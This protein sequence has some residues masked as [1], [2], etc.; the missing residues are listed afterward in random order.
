M[1][2]VGLLVL[3]GVVLTGG[4]MVAAAR[5]VPGAMQP[6]GAR[7]ELTR[8]MVQAVEEVDAMLGTAEEVEPTQL[9][10]EDEVEAAPAVIDDPLPVKALPAATVCVGATPVE[11]HGHTD[12]DCRVH[13]VMVR[14]E[15]S[16]RPESKWVRR[17]A[18]KKS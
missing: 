16:S 4:A 3:A 15:E 14:S 11:L 8:L 10:A 18:L 17:D 7:A 12:S 5:W 2:R 13:I 9:A 1:K 6:A